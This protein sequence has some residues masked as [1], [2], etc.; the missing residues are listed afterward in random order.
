MVEVEVVK[1]AVVVGTITMED[2]GMVIAMET[3][4]VQR[5]IV[6]HRVGLL[7]ESSAVSS[8]A[9]SE[10]FFARMEH[11]KVAVSAV[12]RKGKDHI[13]RTL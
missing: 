1:V 4:A 12:K 8:V 13:I 11:V 10:L 9:S 5:E 2:M 7:V 3:I 6:V